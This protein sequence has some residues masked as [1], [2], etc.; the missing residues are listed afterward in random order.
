MM[1]RLSAGFWVSLLCFIAFQWSALPVLAYITD[2][3]E[4]VVTGA[5]FI[6]GV[7]YP[8]YF[9]GTLVYLHKIKKAAYEDL[10]AAALFLLIP[11]FLY[12]P[13]FELL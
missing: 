3:A 9:I 5:L 8:I 10:M 11:L 1:T 12:F 7:L 13:I 2:R 4:H 6:A